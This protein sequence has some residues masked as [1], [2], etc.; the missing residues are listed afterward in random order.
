MIGPLWT[1]FLFT[2]S[3]YGL[4]ITLSCSWTNHNLLICKATNEFA[5]FCIDN[6]L[7]YFKWVFPK[8]VKV[9]KG[10]AWLVFRLKQA[11]L[12]ICLFTINFMTKLIDSMLLCSVTSRKMSKWGRNIS[13]TLSLGYWLGCHLF[14]SYHILMSPVICHW[15]DAWQNGIC[16]LNALNVG[17]IHN[18]TNVNLI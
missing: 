16:L 11:K 4:L 9:G 17:S 6:N 7:R 13:D 18:K 3:S 10:Y 14:C 15:T 5:S 2:T 12:C 8:F 1:T